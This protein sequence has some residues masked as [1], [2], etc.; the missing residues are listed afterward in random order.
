MLG[1]AITAM[2]SF[3]LAPLRLMLIVG[4]FLKVAG[5]VA[6]VCLLLQANEPN[7]VH[8]ILAAIVF[9]AGL[10]LS[11]VGLLGEYV[12]RNYLENKRRPRFLVELEIP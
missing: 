3:S 12:G 1:L 7:M 5:F 8:W 4:V 9:L 10:Q 6:I 11:S 2:T